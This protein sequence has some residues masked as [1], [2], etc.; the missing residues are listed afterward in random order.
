MKIDITTVI[1]ALEQ[2]VYRAE[3][4]NSF[5]LVLNNALES[6]STN[7]EQ[8]MPA[9]E[10]LG[11]LLADFSERF[12]AQFNQICTLQHMNNNTPKDHQITSCTP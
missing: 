2:S 5:C 11:E 1:N 3:Q 10:L 4:L 7:E 8:Y 12:Q 6:G 9:I